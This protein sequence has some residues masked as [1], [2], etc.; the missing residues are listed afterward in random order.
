MLSSASLR[1]ELNQ[2]NHEAREN[3]VR[4]KMDTKLFDRRVWIPYSIGRETASTS[5]TD[6][7]I[8]S[9]GCMSVTKH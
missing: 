1:P 6:Q 4:K 5:G 8:S 3:T 9:G 2:Y 7:N